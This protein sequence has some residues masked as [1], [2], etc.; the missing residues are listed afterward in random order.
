MALSPAQQRLLRQV[1]ATP[2]FKRASPKERKALVEAGLTESGLRNINY[3][4]R[5]SKGFLQQRPSQGW[6]NPT[7]V[8]TAAKSFLTRAARNNRPGTSAGQLA[9]SVQ[10]SAYPG[11]YDER[12]ADA[13]A[14]LG[15]RSPAVAQEAK[16]RVVD[17]AASAADRRSAIL[18]YV[19]NS[20]DPNAL[21][22]L[23]SALRRPEPTARTSEGTSQG[24]NEGSK[25]PRAPGGIADFE[26]KKVA[27]WIK[28]LLEYAREKG[29]AGHV[30][31]GYR[32]DEEQTRIY[33][34]GVRPA[35]K[36]KA[37]G[38]GGSKHEQTGFL[39][40]AIDVT[41]AETLNRILKAKGSRLKFAGAKDPVHFSVPSGGHY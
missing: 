34:S 30:N 29:W 28:P 15:K 35:A 9:Q 23:A 4:D 31:S 41:D 13:E 33:Q 39:Q 21:L 17:D 12:S 25:S 19:Q 8:P 16:T 27:A 7:H 32:T 36:S 37:L 11:R 1:Y 26:G 38:G 18:A 5:D 24:T 14:I 40:G 6:Q 2:E 20:H 22:G 3:G 10:R